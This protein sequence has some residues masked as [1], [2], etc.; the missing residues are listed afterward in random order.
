EGKTVFVVHDSEGINDQR[1][2]LPPLPFVVGT[3]LDGTIDVQQLQQRIEQR[4]PGNTIPIADLEAIVRDLDQHYLLE[5]DR[6]E[7]RRR[8]IVE[9]Y[10]KSPLRSP[11]FVTGTAVNVSLE[12]DQYFLAKEAAGKPDG[13]GSA[14]GVRA[15]IAP[16]ID[17]QRGGWCYT[18]S[19]REIAERSRADLYV[20]LGVAHVSPQNPLVVTTKSYQTPLGVAETDPEVVAALTRRFPGC[21]EDEIVHRNEHSAEFQAVFLRHVRN[22]APFTV[23]PILCSSFE[24]HCG[25]RSPSTAPRVEEFLQA[26]SEVLKASGRTVCFIAGVDYAH[27]GPRFGD[28]VELDQKLLDCD[29]T[30]GLH[31]CYRPADPFPEVPEGTVLEPGGEYEFEFSPGAW[32][33]L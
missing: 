14:D 15:V 4:F 3:M 27:V 9:S 11:K 8:D 31:L 20:I 24:M 1:L 32:C 6:L 25:E 13:A 30:E 2:I 28:Q 16:H 26:L 17:F 12:L 23:L 18:H 22:T 19:Y 5:S 7:K 21:L 29:G 10:R 33:A